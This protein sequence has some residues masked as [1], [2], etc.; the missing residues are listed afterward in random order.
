MQWSNSARWHIRI[1]RNLDVPLHRW[2]PK[3]HTKN[4]EWCGCRTYAPDG[5]KQS[6][7]AGRQRPEATT[8]RWKWTASTWWQGCTAFDREIKLGSVFKCEPLCSYLLQLALTS[9]I[10]TVRRLVRF[11]N[12]VVQSR[13][14]S[15][16]SFLHH[17]DLLVL[18][19]S[20]WLDTR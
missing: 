18:D 20:S 9:E 6:I 19:Q 7:T 5:W 16:R 10:N 3:R 11:F 12:R 1:S 15:S 4:T 2:L 8:T 13:I 14:T 17:L